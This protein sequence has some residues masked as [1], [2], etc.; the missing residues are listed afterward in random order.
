MVVRL[1]AL[2]ADGPTARGSSPRDGPLPRWASGPGPMARHGGRTA[3][4]TLRP[5]ACCRSVSAPQGF[6]RR[7]GSGGNSRVVDGFACGFAEAFAQVVGGGGAGGAEQHAG[8]DGPAGAGSGRLVEPPE[9]ADRLGDLGRR[10]L[11]AA[12]RA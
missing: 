2:G 8:A 3:A 7:G 11:R 4:P 1:A 6:D 12:G 5:V 10:L 9:L